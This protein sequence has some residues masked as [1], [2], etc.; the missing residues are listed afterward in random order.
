MSA[1]RAEDIEAMS[2]LQ[3][4][5]VHLDFVDGQYALDLILMRS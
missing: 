2:V 5:A 4:K 1:R 3:A